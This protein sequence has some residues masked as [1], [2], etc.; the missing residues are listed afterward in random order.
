MA[1]TQRPM[2][3]NER[4]VY[5]AED[6]L[7]AAA[8]LRRAKRRLDGLEW[9]PAVEDLARDCEHVAAKIKEYAR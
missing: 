7:A 5:A 1:H 2:T 9:T 3:D 4:R 8:A 6:V